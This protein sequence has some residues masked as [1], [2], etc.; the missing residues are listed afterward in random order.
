MTQTKRAADDTH[1]GARFR[2]DLES[3]IE[4]H[5]VLHRAPA[6]IWPGGR[7]E[8]LANKHMASLGLVAKTCAA[9]RS[10]CCSWSRLAR[11]TP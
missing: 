2:G 9:V 4:G 8:W 10:T 1:K 11:F 7:S 6:S 5:S 3:I